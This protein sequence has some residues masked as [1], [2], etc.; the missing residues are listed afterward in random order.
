M[1]SGPVT[2]APVASMPAP[3]PSTVANPLP[4]SL[5]F[6]ALPDPEFQWIPSLPFPRTS[7]LSIVSW[8]LSSCQIPN[9]P[10][11]SEWLCEMTLCP[12]F[13]PLST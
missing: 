8:T 7:L 11:P 1:L 10:L 9:S 2:F 5:F 4:M 13:G 3:L 12:W 6:V